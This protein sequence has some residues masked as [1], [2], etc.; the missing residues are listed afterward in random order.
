M[1]FHFVTIREIQPAAPPIRAARPTGRA[2]IHSGWELGGAGERGI[3]GKPLTFLAGLVLLGTLAGC[4]KG[5]PQLNLPAATAQ[6]S[7][8][9]PLG[10]K[11]AG[12]GIVCFGHVDVEPGVVALFPTQAGR[13]MDV[14]VQ[15]G[16]EVRQG[17]P[18]LQL[19]SRM[20][21]YLLQEAEAAVKSAQ[22]RLTQV[23]QFPDQHA[24]RVAQQQ[25]AIDSAKG[26]L[27]AARFMLARK[28]ELA[29]IGQMNS[30]EVDAQVE[31]VR[32]LEAAEK[33]EYEKLRELNLSDP[34]IL[35][36]QSE[37]E[38]AAAEARCQQARLALDE[39]ILRA[40]TDGTVLRIHAWVGEMITATSEPAMY[41]CPKGPRVV[42]AEVAQEYANRLKE[43]QV[44]II[45]DDASGATAWQGRV[46]RISDWYT[47]RR[48]IL[49]EPRETNDIRTLECIITLTPDQ[50]PLRIGQ[51]VQVTLQP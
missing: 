42:R 41:F 45:R 29:N 27:A 39:C 50:P 26:Y 47:R 30:K 28:R 44:A 2:P 21:R 37:A 10:P 35:I 23:K 24:S 49:R 36:A 7:R 38:L 3:M 40:P 32:Q 18:L 5:Q 48:S 51:R 33:A 1:T 46:T 11:T 14:L 6:D 13:V 22:S 19:D 25:A 12:E 31:Q 8:H 16:Q 17:Q 20:C 4:N 34:A 9:A 15:E 43:G